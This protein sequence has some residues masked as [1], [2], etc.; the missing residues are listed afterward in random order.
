MSGG[1]SVWWATPARPDRHFTDRQLAASDR[2]H[3]PLRRLAVI[4][5]VARVGFLVIAAVVAGAI[6]TAPAPTDRGFGVLVT[7]PALLIGA[8]LTA[9]ALRLPA[10]AVDAWFEYRLE[11]PD[12]A[13]EGTGGAETTTPVPVPWFAV[14]VSALTGLIWLALVIVGALGYGLVANE[15]R[16][17]TILTALVLALLAVATVG[18]R[19]VRRRLPDRERPLAVEAGPDAPADARAPEVVAELDGLAERVGLVGVPYLVSRGGPLR[20]PVAGAVP[21]AC[22]IGVG[23]NRRVVLTERLLAEARPLRDFVVAHELTHLA[24]RHVAAQ[25]V[26]AAVAYTV[27][28]QV[29]G[30]V[31]AD[32]RAWRLFGLTPE[33]PLGMPVVALVLVAVGAVLGPAI[34]LLARAQERMADAGAIASVGPLEPDAARRLHGLAS[35]DLDPPW[36]VRIFDHH[37]AP[38][39][40][41]EFQARARLAR[42]A[43]LESTN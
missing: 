41:L 25:A 8:G 9:A 28:V 12:E 34:A 2:Y 6:D 17:A 10:V 22:A 3:R 11:R 33:D 23:P 43:V 21:N 39:E 16:W 13:G 42:S 4:G 30:L 26:V 15:A 20:S 18:E 7:S 27:T 14:T 24:R 36:W 35:A 40:R 5:H 37:P 19:A 32:G 31:A 1:V 29:L 38:A